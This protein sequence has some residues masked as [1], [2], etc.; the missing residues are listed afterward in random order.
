ML[1][2]KRAVESDPMRGQEDIYKQNPDPQNTF[3]C[4]LIIATV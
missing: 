3:D 1:L 4:L 2:P